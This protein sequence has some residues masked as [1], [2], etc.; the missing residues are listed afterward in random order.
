M[1]KEK[2]GWLTVLTI[3]EKL[4][5]ISDGNGLSLHKAWTMSEDHLQFCQK[6]YF[7]VFHLKLEIVQNQRYNWYY[8]WVS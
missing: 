3:L 5:N 8:K 2:I 7:V 6:E 4:D 1:G